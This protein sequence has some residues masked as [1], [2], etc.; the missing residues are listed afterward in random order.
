MKRNEQRDT[1]GA[2][3][4]LL[5]DDNATDTVIRIC[6]GMLRGWVRQDPALRSWALSIPAE[7][8]AQNVILS[9]VESRDNTVNLAKYVIKHFSVAEFGALRGIDRSSGGYRVLQL[10]Q[11]FGV[12]SEQARDILLDLAD[13]LTLEERNFLG[14]YWKAD[15]AHN[16]TC[17]QS[18]AWELSGRNVF[19][20]KEA[21]RMTRRLSEKLSR[22]GYD[23]EL[24]K[25]SE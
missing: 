9:L 20:E 3:D 23:N 2:Y 11:D 25:A 12:C 16:H 22:L 1:R 10:D 4:T 19:S 17:T 18:Q 21:S 6:A 8:L 14:Y 13:Q 24:A 5:D 7:D 15:K